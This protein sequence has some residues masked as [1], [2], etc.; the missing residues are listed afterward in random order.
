MMMMDIVDQVVGVIS[1]IIELVDQWL[2]IHQRWLDMLT[3]VLNLIF[4]MVIALSH[5]L[6]PLPQESGGTML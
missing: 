2:E 4:M 1:L 5:I 6:Y 3:V